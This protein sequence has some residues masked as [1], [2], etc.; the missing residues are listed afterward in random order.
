VADRARTR[1]LL[2]IFVLIVAAGAVY[3]AVIYAFGYAFETGLELPNRRLLVTLALL[4]SLLFFVFI[5]WFVI[6]LADKIVPRL[7]RG[8]EKNDCPGA[9]GSE[10]AGHARPKRVGFLPHLLARLAAGLVAAPVALFLTIVLW[11]ASFMMLTAC[12]VNDP[13]KT[14]EQAFLLSKQFVL[15]N[16][17]ERLEHYGVDASMF[18]HS[19]VGKFSVMCDPPPRFHHA[20][21]GW[22]GGFDVVWAAFLPGG[23]DR[24][25]KIVEVSAT[26]GKCGTVGDFRISR[27]DKLYRNKPLCPPAYWPPGAK[28][29]QSAKP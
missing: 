10:T 9:D 23:C 8:K 11:I 14:Q 26:V 22:G 5:I 1:P 27:L 2:T 4:S 18:E 6:A 7:C 15:M 29:E 25:W 16:E 24:C 12:L 3:L 21:P 28:P 17:M 20:R 19:E 13:V